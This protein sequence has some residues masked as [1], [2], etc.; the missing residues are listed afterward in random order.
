LRK[1]MMA[2]LENGDKKD[3]GFSEDS[4][5]PEKGLYLSCLESKGWH[6]QSD[7]GF[8]FPNQSKLISTDENK[9]MIGLWSDGFDY[10]RNSKRMITIDE[11]YSY[12]MKPPYGLTG[13]LCRIFG[14]ALLKSLEGKIAFYDLD[15]T[16]QFIFIPELDEE[17]VTKIYKHPKEAGVRYYEISEIQTHL[18][19]TLAKAT[20]G[21]NEGDDVVLGIAKH[22]VKIVHTLPAWVKKTSGESFS[23][24][25]NH[26]GLT[27]NARNFRNKVLAAHDPYK[28]ILDDLPEIF[29]L[30][31]QDVDL[32]FKLAHCLKTAIEDL[33]AQHDMLLTGFMKVIQIGLGAKADSEELKT[34]CEKVFSIAQRPNVKELASRLIKYIDGKSNFEQV[35]NLAAGVAERNWTDKHLRNGLDELKNLCVQFRR[36]ESFSQVAGPSESKPLAFI[37]S[38]QLGNHK[39]YFA[40]INFDIDNDKDVLETIGNVKS[41]LQNIP[42]DKQLAVLSSIL[43]GLMKLEDYNEQ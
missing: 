10:I 25:D 13:G 40:Y 28:L 29:K 16:K 1:L 14:L 41:S 30:D 34:R 19:N 24:N 11:L 20:I 22:I 2:M 17:L 18:L 9:K 35:I 39:E 38:D 5:P 7:E 21:N 36:I 33:S 8:V 4:F 37:T 42:E 27:H 43:S 12:W 15:S 32:E 23:S 31:I 26:Q 3:L 6:I